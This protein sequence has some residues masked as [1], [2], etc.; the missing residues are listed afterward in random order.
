MSGTPPR[1]P[2]PDPD[3]GED[4]QGPQESFDIIKARELPTAFE[5]NGATLYSELPIIGAGQD[6]RGAEFREGPND[7][8][9][10]KTKIP[11]METLEFLMWRSHVQCCAI[12]HGGATPRLSQ[13]SNASFR[14]CSSLHVKARPHE[15]VPG[16]TAPATVMGSSAARPPSPLPPPPPPSR[17]I[18]VIHG[19][20]FLC[21]PLSC[22]SAAACLR[23]THCTAQRPAARGTDTLHRPLGGG[24][25]IEFGSRRVT[26]HSRLIRCRCPNARTRAHPLSSRHD[27]PSGPATGPISRPSSAGRLVEWSRIS[28][29]VGCAPLKTQSSGPARQPAD[30]TDS[31]RS[32]FLCRI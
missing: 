19:L 1:A 20:Q 31:A 18:S 22:R 17:P 4:K 13:T 10:A 12:C 24:S 11:E 29:V 27:A 5:Q 8:S 25:R 16:A 7:T 21:P 26:G 14:E 23:R 30:S 3:I 28:I 2:M 15:Y 9:T 6:L 32:P